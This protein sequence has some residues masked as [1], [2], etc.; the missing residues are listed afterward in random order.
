MATNKLINSTLSDVFATDPNIA[1]WTWLK[2]NWTT[3][4]G[5]TVPAVSSIKF[6]TKFGSTK[7]FFNYV[8]VE[9]INRTT[10]PQTLGSARY[11]SDDTKRVQI[12][13]VGPSSKNTIYNMER[14]IESLIN[15]N[16]TGMQSDGIEIFSI[17]DFQDLNLESESAVTKM[18]PNKQ[19]QTSRAFATVTLTY[20]LVQTT[21]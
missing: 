21:V 4:T 13:C 19:Y 16:P 12:M 6:D 7:G 11:H 5:Y 8:I 17:T 2:N 15:G 18:T 10:T 1:L 14:H 9:S 20:D 3:S